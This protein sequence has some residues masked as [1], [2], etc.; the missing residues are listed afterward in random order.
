MDQKRD[1]LE[2]KDLRR[3]P[4][5]VPEGY[6]DRLQQR[7]ERIPRQAEVRPN[8]LAA[9]LTASEHSPA[10]ASRTRI[11]PVLAWAMGIAAALAVGVFVFRGGDGVSI[12]S[13]M[14]EEISYE[15]LAYADLIPYTDP[16]CYYG[17]EPQA[18][19][20]KAEE[21]MIDYLMQYQNY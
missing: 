1:I 20:D 3:N 12:D 21:E 6:F 9:N 2:R 7:L 14:P 5:S 18:P 17:E 19:S 8:E 13:V 16:Y 11:R 15:Q 4:Y 10:E